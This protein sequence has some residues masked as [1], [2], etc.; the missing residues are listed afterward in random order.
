M[1][2]Q[3]TLQHASNEATQ[4]SE[5]NPDRSRRRVRSAVVVLAGA[6]AALAVW[7]VAVPALGVDLSARMGPTVQAVGPVLIA[8]ETIVAGL[9][10]WGVRALI[11]RFT[12]RARTIWLT[13]ATIIL[14]ISFAGPLMSAASAAATTT[15][16]VMHLIVG[17]MFTLG[18]APRRP[19]AR[20]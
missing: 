7:A 18:L 10:A 12:R 15:F 9:V 14:V 17:G 20:A 6:L 13:L 11:E 8:V 1:N 5:A 4:P 19:G 16:V 2:E 3:T